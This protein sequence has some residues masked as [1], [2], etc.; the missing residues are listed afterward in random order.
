MRI[1]PLDEQIRR[2]IP[3]KNILPTAWAISKA[4]SKSRENCCKVWQSSQ[5]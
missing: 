3:H 4:I 2:Q 1:T 5:L